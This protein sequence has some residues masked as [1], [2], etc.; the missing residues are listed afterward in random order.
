VP[1]WQTHI[2]RDTIGLN[3]NTKF[4][5]IDGALDGS[6][7]VGTIDLWGAATTWD[8]K[9]ILRDYNGGTVQ[10]YTTGAT[11]D[12]IN[13]QEGLGT[14][15]LTSSSLT[16]STAKNLDIRGSV[17]TIRGNLFDGNTHSN[18]P[19]IRYSGTVTSGGYN[20]SDKASGII[21]LTFFHVMKL[22]LQ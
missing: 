1:K 6:G 5:A 8:A 7:Q 10:N 11:P 15:T 16:I 9:P 17:L 13:V 4:I 14:I 19:V 2:T 21:L 18:Y 22:F 12:I 20:V 3:G